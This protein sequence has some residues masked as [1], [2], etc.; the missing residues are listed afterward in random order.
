VKLVVVGGNAAG[1]SGASKAKR[2]AKD[3]EVEVLEAG[4]DISYSSC[5][6]PHFVEGTVEDADQ[7]RVLSVKDAAKRGIDV[8]TETKA[9]AVNP[10][11][12]EVVFEGPEGRDS[13]HYDRLLLAMG[14][15]ARNPFAGKEL[16]GVHTVRHLGDGLR[17]RKLMESGKKV[18]RFSVVGGGYA[19]LEMAVALQA[20]G[21]KVNVFARGRLLSDFDADITEGLTDYLEQAG[22]KIHTD[23]KVQGFKGTNGRLTHL[24]TKDDEH[25]TDAAIVAVGV[26]PATGFVQK[27]GISTDK[28]GYI[29]VDDQMKTNMHD[30]WAA[31]DCVATRHLITGQQ[32]PMPLALP[33]NRMG[34]VAGDNIAAS[35]DKI[36]GNSQFYAGSLGTTIV[37]LYGLAFAKTGLSEEEARKEGFEVAAALIESPTKAGYMPGVGDMA[38]KVVADKTNGKM[39]GVQL[40][41]PEHA[42]LRIDAAAVALHAG[43]KVSKFADAETAYAPPFS[44]VWDPLLVAAGECAKLVGKK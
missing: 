41:G 15:V 30:V 5:G 18:K 37:R 39:L 24:E 20:R 32:V 4:A 28:A 31:G 40:A 33:A 43:L 36:P 2:R 27:S 6:I 3:L 19:G 34:R 35:L 9:V 17:I 44:P 16:E 1:M 12:K 23:A 42:A 22:M 8:R 14:T 13:V 26:E 11:T 29:L 10:Y 38:V 21:A 7:L 25:P